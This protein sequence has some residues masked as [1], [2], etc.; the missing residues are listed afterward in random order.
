MGKMNKN[1][2]FTHVQKFVQEV[3][4]E[5][6]REAGF[7]SYRNEGVHWFRLV[8]DEVIQAVYFVA[9]HTTFPVRLD[10]EYGCHPLFIPP[11]LQHSPYMYGMPGYEQMYDEIQ[12]TIPGRMPDGRQRSMVLGMQNREYREDIEVLC[13]VNPDERQQILRNVLDEIEPLNTPKACFEAHKRWRAR[14]IENDSWGIMSPYFVEEVLYW[15]EESLYPYCI[16]YMKA[17]IRGL[18]NVREDGK[19]PQKY[20]QELEHLKILWDV[21]QN[22][23]RAEYLQVLQGR[24]SKNRKRLKTNTSLF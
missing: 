15:E 1:A 8:N 13:P 9:R 6:L 2:L 4:A 19:L 22:N 17:T 14:Q 16:E 24:E 5:Q 18:S 7:R 20:Q 23:S 11:I 12:E 10:I 21:F 3:Y